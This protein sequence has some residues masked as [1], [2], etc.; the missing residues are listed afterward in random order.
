LGSGNTAVQVR[1]EIVVKALRYAEYGGPEVLSVDEV[2]APDAG[3]G[4]V[5]ISVRAA[6]VNPI[7]WKLRSGAFASFMAQDLP[8]HVGVDAAGV[9]D[10]VGDGVTD[11]AVGDRVFGP[12]AGGAMQEFALLTQWVA[13][14]ERMSFEEAAGIPVPAETARRTLNLLGV[15]AGHTLLVDGAAGGV[16][17]AVVQFAVAQ[18]ATVIGTASERNHDYLRSL[19]AQVTTYGP[20]LPERVAALA[21]NG[22]D[23][24]L[25]VAGQGGIADLV[26]ITGNPDHVL[27]IADPK[28][29]ELGVTM[30]SGGDD[31]APEGRP[32]AAALFE[33]GKFTMPVA[34]TFPLDK[35]AA[36]YQASEAGHVRGKYV[37]TIG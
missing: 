18:G 25:D 20:G 11:V 3:K 21:P 27:T 10:Q 7:D 34:E 8:A 33:Q 6:G 29:A 26:A 15:T 16:G 5:R 30:T 19:G 32:E 24:A 12:T 14:P 22:V 17:L 23:R 2:D 9:V 1:E 37:I 28:A 35:A 36:A 13:M 4:Q 31:S